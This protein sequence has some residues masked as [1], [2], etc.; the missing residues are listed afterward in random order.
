MI[1][2]LRPAGLLAQQKAGVA[3]AGRADGPNEHR[4]VGS[5]QRGR[6]GR[7]VER[8]DAAKRRHRRGCVIVLQDHLPAIGDRHERAER[9]CFCRRCQKRRRV[10]VR[11]ECVAPR[12]RRHRRCAGR[13]RAQ[14]LWKRGR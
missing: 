8:R 5:R 11:L 4:L 1:L 3:R 6:A 10:I 12:R 2:S 14:G 7:V 13:A 9:Q